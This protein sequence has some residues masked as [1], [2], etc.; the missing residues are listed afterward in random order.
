MGTKKEPAVFNFDPASLAPGEKS[1]VK[2]ELKDGATQTINFGPDVSQH[3]TSFKTEFKLNGI[4]LWRV[5]I[6]GEEI[7]TTESPIRNPRLKNENKELPIA[8]KY[9]WKL[10]GEFYIVG[11]G[12]NREYYEGWIFFVNIE[13]VI[14]FDHWELYR[15]E[16]I[17]GKDNWDTENLISEPISGKVIGNTVQL[18]WPEFNSP[19]YYMCIP[20]KSYL[21]NVPYR[22]NFD[23]TEFLGYVSREQLPLV[24][25]KVITAGISDWLKYKITLKKE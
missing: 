21:G 20:R 7:D 10:V 1:G 18:K 23:S 25:G 17:K 16:K 9:K 6:E 11:K 14:Q 8:M 19:E 5:L 4:E 24:D 13:P 15:V 2:I 3:I 12:D 22:P